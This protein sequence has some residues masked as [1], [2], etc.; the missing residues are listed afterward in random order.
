MKHSS[1]MIRAFHPFH[2]WSVVIS[3]TL[4]A[5]LPLSVRAAETTSEK[6]TVVRQ[7]PEVPLDSLFS[8]LLKPYAGKAV[9]VDFWNTWC[10]PCRRA[11]EALEP[12][13]PGLA[14]QGLVFLYLADESSPIDTWNS[15]IPS[16]PGEHYR[17]TA[18]QIKYLRQQFDI[19]G[20][21]FYLV[22][23]KQG[24]KT[25]ESLGFPGVE[26]IQHAVK[27]VL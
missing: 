16:I 26:A 6:T 3:A 1:A 13:K 27:N 20:I 10:G 9:L 19:K 25:Y 8:T 24:V 7:V 2:S 12:A 4:L 5:F 18:D 14:N 11:M 21:P 23:D 15:M 22:I 17:L